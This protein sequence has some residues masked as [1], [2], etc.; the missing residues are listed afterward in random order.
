MKHYSG[1]DDWVP[2]AAYSDLRYQHIKALEQERRAEEEC[3]RLRAKIAAGLPTIVRVNRERDNA[4]EQARRNANGVIFW[5]EKAKAL[6]VERD[7][8][9]AWAL[10][11][12]RLYL[13][14]KAERDRLRAALDEHGD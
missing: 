5:R 1:S 3:A 7:E 6:A 2:L 12:G 4:L 11:Y 8:A 10:R 9:R 14:A 13:A